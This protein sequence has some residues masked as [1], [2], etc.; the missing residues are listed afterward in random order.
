M[1]YQL[2]NTPGLV[3]Q[4]KNLRCPVCGGSPEIVVT[5]A[6]S[7]NLSYCHPALRELCEQLEKATVVAGREDSSRRTVKLKRPDL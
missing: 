4:L 5:S 2:E 3:D 6:T 7:Y 1:D